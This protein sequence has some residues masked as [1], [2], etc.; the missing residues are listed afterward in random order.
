[1]LCDDRSTVIG[2]NIV[3]Y[4]R[5]L[6]LLEDSPTQRDSLRVRLE[7]DGFNVLTPSGHSECLGFL[8]YG[9]KTFLLDIDMGGGKRRIEGLAALEDIKKAC[10]DAFCAMVTGNPQF[11]EKARKFGADMF[12]SKSEKDLDTLV[13]KLNVVYL[14]RRFDVKGPLT[15]AAIGRSARHEVIPSLGEVADELRA[16][17]PYIRSH[18][19]SQQY[20]EAGLELIILEPGLRQLTQLTRSFGDGF[21]V[22][23]HALRNA[24]RNHAGGELRSEL[25]EGWTSAFEKV[26]NSPRLDS[27]MS[28][29]LADDLDDL[30]FA[31]EPPGWNI[32]SDLLMDTP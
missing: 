21:G 8:H 6:A 17:F 9:C 10:P 32:M 29:Q 18:V 22:A 12:I 27:S 15:L 3:D 23:I 19:D 24:I 4:T 25:W 30:G 5:D 14:G 20:R 2:A 1:M 11:R 13:E 7:A 28:S 16:L 26:M 31:T